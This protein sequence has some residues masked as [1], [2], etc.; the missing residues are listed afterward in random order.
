VKKAFL[1]VM[2]V[3][4]LSFT[5]VCLPIGGVAWAAP[6]DSANDPII[7]TTAAQ[8]DNVRN[9]LKKFYRLNNNIDLAP[10]L[11]SGG[12]GF[13]KWGSAGW[14]PIGTSSSSFTGSFNGNGY[15]I[16]GLWINRSSMNNVGL[17]GYI[18]NATIEKLGVEITT[19][20]VKGSYYVGGLVG[21]QVN[22]ST[23][24]SYA[25]G[26]IFGLDY[27]GGLIGYMFANNGN[28][29]L[30][31]SYATGD[32]NGRV[33]I[34]G[35]VGGQYSTN[36]NNNFNSI[37]NSYATGNVSGTYYHVGGLVGEQ[38]TNSSGSNNNTIT[39][40]YA[41][42]N[43]SAPNYAGGLVGCQIGGKVM[44]SY[45]TGNVSR[46]SNSSNSG[47]QISGLVGGQ[48]VFPCVI[49]NSYRYQL[50]KINGVVRTENTPN[51]VH[52][53][54]KTEIQLKTQST[55]TSTGWVFSASGPWYW[56]S[57]GFPKLNMGVENYPFSISPGDTASNPIIITTAA[58]LDN[59]RNGLNK[60][61][62][63]N[64]NIDLTSYLASGGAGY[65]KWGTAGWLPIGTNSTPF[66]GSFDGNGYKITGLWINRSSTNYMG[67]FGYIKG[68]TIAKLGVMIAAAG[69]ISSW[70]AGGLAGYAVDGNIINCY[71]TGNV[72]ATIRYAGGL[73]A[74]VEGGNITNCYATGNISGTDSGGLAGRLGNGNITNSYATGNV[75]NTTDYVGGLVGSF[76]SN[77]SI[78]NCYATGNISGRSYIGGLVGWQSA[79]LGAHSNIVNS[80]ATGNVSGTSNSIGGL[81]GVQYPDSN[82]SNCVITNCYA[83]GNVKGSN[84]VSGLVGSQQGSGSKI[85]TNSYRY[86]FATINDVVRTENTPNGIHGGIKTSTQLNTQSTYTSA[87]W[88]FSAVGPWYW[89]SRGFPKLNMGTENNPFPFAGT[90]GDSR[91]N[92][93]TVTTAAQLDN[94]R[95]GLNKYY[96]LNNNIDLTSY[97]ASGGAGFSKWGAA[98]WLPIGTSSAPFTGGFDGNGYKITGL[99]IDR[100][101]MNDVGLFGYTRG[102]TIVKLGVDIAAAGIKGNNNVGGLAGWLGVSGSITNCYVTG[103][104][105]GVNNVG[106]LVGWQTIG[107]IISNSYARG[108]VIGTD[109]IGGLLGHQGDSVSNCYATGYV[110]ATKG[111]AGGLVGWQSSGSITNSYA[112]GEVV[113]NPAGGLLGLQSIGVLLGNITNSYATG[114]VSG[115]SAGGLVGKQTSLISSNRIVNSYRYQYAMINGVF[116]T[117][118]T[119]NGIHGGIRTAKQLETQSTYTGWTFSATGPWYWDKAGFPKLN[120]GT[121]YYPFLFVTN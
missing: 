33:S 44:N 86:Q 1:V 13:A 47:N 7:I 55:Y 93:I 119:P 84:G 74:Y 85:I 68:A 25:K 61:Y 10:Y 11:A 2:V 15:K 40:S 19:A 69:I 80:Y 57:R 62:R 58:Q 81:V 21:T 37:S 91:N 46:V 20:G 8:L 115:T 26:N 6:G 79:S 98:G 94:V 52:G 27:I 39:N 23:K 95:N 14:M 77:S 83:I 28:T 67:L 36:S 9:G 16:T 60:Y 107:G 29:S 99:R 56:D 3:L 103:N 71:T 118:N 96:W 87:G 112:T 38:A 51:G 90:P 53:G 49:T 18:S 120:M 4:A 97:L 41:T 70:Y 101:S 121:E 22:G 111:N 76:G 73:V 35:L 12:A 17:F 109:S 114:H 116:R 31:N 78:T 65:A 105:S 117:E 59:V 5:T 113:G 75:T 30:T 82:N 50:A 110:K 72:T 54:V 34:G 45:S 24:N 42:G 43:V 100:S 64:N 102:A 92:P 32:V 106:G 88:T 108:D 63:L 104:V 89:D 48:M 66:T